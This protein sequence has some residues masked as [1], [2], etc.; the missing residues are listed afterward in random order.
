MGGSVPSSRV[1]LLSALVLLG[2]TGCEEELR[3]LL[4]PTSLEIVLSALGGPTSTTL[5]V[6]GSAGTANAD[7]VHGFLI[8][9]AVR[10]LIRATLPATVRQKVLQA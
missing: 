3:P 9:N 6:M 8:G 5:E 4:G 7:L 2:A 1:S 10:G